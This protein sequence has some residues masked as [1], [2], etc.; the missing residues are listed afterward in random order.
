[1]EMSV[2]RESHNPDLEINYFKM[3]LI[4]YFLHSYLRSQQYWLMSLIDNLN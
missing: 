3:I 4:L 1:M 2:N